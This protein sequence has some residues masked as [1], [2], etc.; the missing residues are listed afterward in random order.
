MLGNET[1]CSDCEVENRLLNAVQ[2]CNAALYRGRQDSNHWL[3]TMT[4][5]LV[6]GSRVIL[7]HCG[8][9]RAYLWQGNRL[10]QLTH[11]H[12]M[13]ADLVN[14]GHLAN[15]DVR[16]HPRRNVLSSCL[17]L[18]AKA[19]IDSVT[20]P[21][22]EGWVLLLCSDGVSSAVDFDDLG[23]FVAASSSSTLQRIAEALVEKSGESKLEDDATALLVR[24]SLTK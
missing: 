24:A 1:C 16:D 18:R 13:V 20:V 22:D 11:D 5:M 4:V 6:E 21:I 7:T 17:G 8:D 9:S 10:L 15:E 14:A 19:R 23:A 3:S 2:H 12:T